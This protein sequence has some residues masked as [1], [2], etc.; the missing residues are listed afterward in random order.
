MCYYCERMGHIVAYRPVLKR[1]NAKPVA[2]VKTQQI[3][4]IPILVEGD[5]LDVF[6][7]FIMKGF[8]SIEGMDKVPANI[9]LDTAASQYFILED[10]LPFSSSTLVGSD[11]PVMSFGVSM[12]L[13]ND[14]A[15]GKVLVTPDV[16]PV[17]LLQCPDELAQKYPRVLHHV[18]LLVQ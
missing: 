5:D 4:E 18:L 7:P 2:L 14:L 9:L 10:V 11:V 3:L 8:V 1:K 15:G 12:I 16:T 13:G 17:P 6:A